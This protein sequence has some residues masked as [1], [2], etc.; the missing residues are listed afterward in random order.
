MLNVGIIKQVDNNKSKKKY[1]VNF[2]YQDDKNK[3]RKAS[4]RFGLKDKQYLVDSGDE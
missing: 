4:V 1:C 3:K 2:E